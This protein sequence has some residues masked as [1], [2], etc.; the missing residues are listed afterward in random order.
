MQAQQT[1]PQP[2]CPR[3]TTESLFCSFVTS[4]H[5]LFTY[6]Q[7]VMPQGPQARLQDTSTSKSSVPVYQMPEVSFQ[8]YSTN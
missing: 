3:T 6:D 7:K 2:H 1:S 4:L 8:Q 5:F